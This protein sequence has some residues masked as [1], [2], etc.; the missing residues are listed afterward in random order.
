MLKAMSAQDT[1][2]AANAQS[3]QVAKT[4]RKLPSANRVECLIGEVKRTPEL[5][6]SQADMG[7]IPDD[8]PSSASSMLTREQ[9]DEPAALQH[10][11]AWNTWA[12]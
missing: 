2:E 7:N 8:G 10:Y 3:R 1:A 5:V 11:I 4:V 6:L 9:N 12:L